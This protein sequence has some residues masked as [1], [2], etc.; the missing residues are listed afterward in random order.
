MTRMRDGNGTVW[1]VRNGEILRVGNRSQGF[2]ARHRRPARRRTAR[3]STRPA[4]PCWPTADELVRE[5]DDRRVRCSRSRSSPASRQIDVERRRGA[6]DDGEGAPGRP[7]A[8][9]RARC[10]SGS[11]TRLDETGIRPGDGYGLDVHTEPARG[12]PAAPPADGSGGQPPTG[13]TDSDPHARADRVPGRDAGRDARVRLAMRCLVTGATGY[14][15]GRLVPELLD[16]GSPRARA[17]PHARAGCGTCRG[18]AGSRSSQGDAPTRD[19]MRGR[20]GRRRRRLLPGALARHRRRLRGDRPA[21]AH[22]LRRRRA[23]DAGVGRIVYLGG[24]QPRRRGALARTCASR[25]EVGEILLGS[26]VPTVVLRAAVIIGSGSA[27][28]EML[29]YLTERLP[30]MVTPALGAATGSSRS[31]SATCCATWSASPTLPADVEPRL[32]HRRPGRADLRAR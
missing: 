21:T 6:A 29:R 31:R 2:V 9:R 4:R 30:V 8:D 24:L 28:F 15:G 3:T 12:E 13:P 23:S 1:Y 22:D 14:I 16:A 10:G 18:S 20:A 7:V 25:A 26:G 11:P 19:A 27:S 17:G 5:D 32:R